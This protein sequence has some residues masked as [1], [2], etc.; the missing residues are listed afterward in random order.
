MLVTYYMILWHPPNPSSSDKRRHLIIRHPL[1]MR[2]SPFLLQFNL[3]ASSSKL[4][5]DDICVVVSLNRIEYTLLLV[6]FRHSLFRIVVFIYNTHIVKLGPLNS[7][8]K[9]VSLELPSAAL[10]GRPR[11]GLGGDKLIII[12]RI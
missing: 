2:F 9:A 12:V 6:I 8:F 11:G 10:S 5:F 4:W 7:I 1:R 3:R